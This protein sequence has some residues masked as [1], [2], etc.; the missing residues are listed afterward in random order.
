MAKVHPQ[1]DDAM[2]AWIHAQ[3]IYFVASAPLAANGHINLSP[4]GLD[5]LRV[6]GPHQVAFLDLTGSGN[7]TAAHLL[8]NSRITIML[9]A[10]EGDPQILRFYGRGETVLSGD[11]R[12]TELRSHFPD[13]FQLVRQIIVVEVERIQ[14]S[15]GYGVPLMAFQEQRSHL[16]DWSD[17]KGEQGILDYQQKN[18][19][20]SIDGLPTPLLKED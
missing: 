12:W 15:C 20:H 2:A 1:I 19:L 14:T 8:E 9:C 18:N 13:S 5:T 16:L 3:P 11:A 6:L 17:K 4:R 7:E 10:F